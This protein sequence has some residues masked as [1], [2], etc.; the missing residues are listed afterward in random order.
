MEKKS[1]VCRGKEVVL[2]LLRKEWEVPPC[3]RTNCVLLSKVNPLCFCVKNEGGGVQNKGWGVLS[4]FR[5]R[6]FVCP[7]EG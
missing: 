6:T 4:H 7:L 5:K 3:S 1:G 2:F